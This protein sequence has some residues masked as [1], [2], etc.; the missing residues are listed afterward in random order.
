MVLTGSFDHAIRLWDPS[1]GQ[2]LGLLGGKRYHDSHVNAMVF[3]HKTGRLYSGD[4]EGCI[5]IWRKA[6]QGK[7]SSGEDYVVMRKIDK[8]RELKGRAIVSLNLNPARPTGRGHILIMAHENTLR[9][10]DLST[11]RL[12]E[13]SYS[14]ADNHDSIVRACY[15]ACG[16]Y[17]VA[18]TDQGAVMVWDSKSGLRI[19]SELDS[20]QYAA[21]LNSVCWHPT[22]HVVAVSSYG[23]DFPVLMYS[24]DRDPSRGV[25]LVEEGGEV[26]GGE[27][28][29]GG[30][31]RS[32]EEE[33]ER[34]ELLEE[35]RRANRERYAE[36]KA[37]AMQRR[38]E[39]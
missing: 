8:L 19:S 26:E 32:E 18:G 39:E 27:R 17:V 35:K 4:G 29:E 34:K 3:D 10:F 36:L 37:K 13:A 15:S 21:P 1:T 2:N 7:V 30:E 22:Q 16:K 24:A 14:G 38:G 28:G 23:G 33:R 9:V 25:E 31:K 12:T 5:V 20:I 11:Q 6:G